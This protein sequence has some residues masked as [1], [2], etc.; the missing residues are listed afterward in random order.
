MLM[1]LKNKKE[2]QRD[3]LRVPHSKI[4]VWDKTKI[5]DEYTLE[6]TY[7][8]TKLKDIW[9][10]VIPQTGKLQRGQVDNILANVT[11][12]IMCRYEG[13]KDITEDM[14]IMFRGK[15]FDIKYILNPH[16]KNEWLELFCEEVIE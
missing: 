6:E 14:H 15:R 3:L 2:A 16:F 4:E 8:E 10:Q 9:A 13:G 12:K 11:H 7:I 5:E 1:I